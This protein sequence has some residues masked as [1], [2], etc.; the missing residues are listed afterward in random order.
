MPVVVLIALTNVS[1]SAASPLNGF[2]DQTLLSG[3]TKNLNIPLFHVFLQYLNQVQL[4]WFG[5]ALLAREPQNTALIG[6][7]YLQAV[8]YD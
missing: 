1:V 2:L 4:A 8:Q 7:P 6:G 3:L 5:S